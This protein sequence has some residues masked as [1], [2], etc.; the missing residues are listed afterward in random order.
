MRA[1]QAAAG[2]Q[3]TAEQ[4][5]GHPEG[6][7]GHDVVRPAGETEV[8]GVGLDDHDRIAEAPAEQLGPPG[9]GFD[10][11]DPGAG[12]HQRRSERPVSRA[13]VDHH[14]AASDGGVSDEALCPPIVE[15]VPAPPSA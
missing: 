13:D 1:E 5:R 7:V 15:L 4:R 6:W 12:R 3:E 8:G 2:L 9:V 11:D 14:G 10:G